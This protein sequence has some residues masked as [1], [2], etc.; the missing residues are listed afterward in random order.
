MPQFPQACSQIRHAVYGLKA[1]S[2]VGQQQV[3][4]CTGTAF[5]IHPGVL[6]TAAHCVHIENNH[7][8]PR[9]TT[10]QVIRAPDVGQQ[11]ENCTFVAEDTD[12]DI[13]LLRIEQSR[14]NTCVTLQTAQVPNGTACGALGFPLASVNPATGMFNL[15][16]RFQGARISA[17]RASLHPSGRT[18]SYYETDSV[19]Y[20]GSSGCPG[21]INT[22]EVFG[23][24]NGSV[25]DAPPTGVPQENARLAIS[26]WTPAAD[27]AQFARQN[28]IQI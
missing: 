16:E 22:A 4:I 14:A 25:L 13:A 23:L 6:A 8:R 18:F 1:V 3:N 11:M 12:R 28:G 19:M 21:F 17:Y 20:K 2:Q 24:H 26:V 15:I 27:I 9:H 5:M 7:T 10:F